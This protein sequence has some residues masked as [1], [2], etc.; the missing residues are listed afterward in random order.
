MRAAQTSGAKATSGADDRLR[1]RYR[2]LR[3]LLKRNST[4]LQMLADLESDLAYVEPSEDPIRAALYRLVNEALLMSEELCLLA[5]DKHTALY[6]A[7]ADVEAAIDRT[8]KS[9]PAQRPQALSVGL[10]DPLAADSRLCGGK[11]AGL[12]ALSRL[13][14]DR[15][16]PGFVVTTDAYG[17]FVDE[18]GLLDRIR[19]PLDD[20][21]A[22]ADRDLFASRVAA[23]REMF[24]EST[25]PAVV[26]DEIAARAAEI[27]TPATRWAV[28]S[29]ARYE[30][31]RFSFAGQFDTLLDVPTDGLDDAYRRVLAGRF[32][33]RAV[34]YRAYCGFR[35]V[36]T[37][38]AVL[39]MPM[40]D[41]A[42]AG[43]L[44]T[45]DP[46]E[47]DAERMPA[48]FVAGVSDRL[49]RGEVK[50]DS[51]VL[52]KDG[53]P[54]SALPDYVN[55][56]ALTAL[57]KDAAEAARHFGYDLDAEWAIDREGR[58][59]LLQ[60]RRLRVL[61]S[62]E[63]RARDAAKK[64]PLIERG[65]T[66]SPGR[67]EGAVERLADGTTVIARKAP[68]VVVDVATPELTAILPEI[69]ALL[70]VHGNPSGHA[71][72]LLR[73]YA[74]PTVFQIGDAAN[75]LAEGETVSVDA[76]RRRIF[77]G[78]RWEGVRERVLSRV[79]AE[80]GGPTAGPLHDLVLALHL[81]DPY[82]RTFKPAKCRSVHDVIRYVHEMSIRSLFEIGDKQNRFWSRGAR[83]LATELPFKVKLI[84]LENRTPGSGDVRPEDV[85][86]VP[87]QAY[88]R[89][90]S[91]P[92]VDWT[93]HWLPDLS[94]VPP[95]YAD[96]FLGGAAG[97]RRK[98]T[99][100][101]AVVAGDYLNLNVRVTY[102]YAMID[103]VI[104]SGKEN[105]HVHFRM[106]GGEAD[107]AKRTRRARFME[108]VLRDGHFVVDRKGDLVT[109][110]LRGYPREDSEEALAMLGR[111]MA[112]AR[113]LDVYM[114][115]DDAPRRFASEF[116]AGNYRAFL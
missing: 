28:R 50:G 7:I 37:P 89:G 77:R 39:F 44:Y 67:A 47:P 11:A 73:E 106:R 20:I 91:D 99:P 6:D 17:R 84:D 3:S 63:K 56:K 52:S 10:L 83:T 105:N 49:L 33:D 43:V 26:Q 110:W 31:E 46:H 109:A 71:A 30:D 57:A 98:G 14:C 82:A 13:V 53:A 65:V 15:V 75:L 94:A 45:A 87:F 107:E 90:V 108:M 104:T 81:T 111:L 86:S 68:V 19:R 25:T 41:A 101:Y 93:R 80:R 36:D 9:G 116:A 12:A 1:G 100:N 85:D 58:G 92:A 103:A 97:P 38:M 59:W 64:P 34:R 72:A 95:G 51:A 22:V 115:N 88:W 23:V 35:E 27:A 24:M 62:P 60:G 5:G 16:P 96:A 48:T 8:F 78:R 70:V 21:D 114:A 61:P 76:S 54:R 79:R 102:H 69:A 55:E 32:T 74:V 18:N 29:S 4:A 66:I 2:V 42:A 113:Q 112:C 40:I